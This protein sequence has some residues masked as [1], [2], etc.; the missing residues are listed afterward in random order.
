[1]PLHS[2]LD[3][4]EIPPIFPANLAFQFG[5]KAAWSVRGGRGP[6]GYVTRGDR[7]QA[8]TVIEITVLS[9]G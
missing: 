6:I 9:A 4:V 8:A 5:K 1:M 7:L 3:R 2:F